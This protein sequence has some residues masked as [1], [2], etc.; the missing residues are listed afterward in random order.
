MKRLVS[1]AEADSGRLRELFANS[2]PFN[3]L[4]GLQTPS[5]PALP[6]LQWEGLFVP[7]P[8]EDRPILLHNKG[9]WVCLRK[10]GGMMS[11]INSFSRIDKTGGHACQ[12]Q[13]QFRELKPPSATSGNSS[14]FPEHLPIRLR[15]P[16]YITQW[17]RDM[18]KPPFQPVILD[19]QS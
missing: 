18:Q 12:L 8:C 15:Y 1:G 3:H 17:V 11:T 5:L 4:F 16:E 9:L 19:F 6:L 2:T 7:P 14:T 13:R 10:R